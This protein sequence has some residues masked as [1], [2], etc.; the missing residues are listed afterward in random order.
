MNDIVSN[1]AART[2]TG[3]TI[4]QAWDLL[5][6]KYPILLVAVLMHGLRNVIATGVILFFTVSSPLSPMFVIFALIFLNVLSYLEIVAMSLKYV[7]GE[8]ARIRNVSGWVLT[9]SWLLSTVIF[10]I[11]VAFGLILLVIPGFVL[12][13]L[14]SVY[15]FAAVDGDGPIQSLRT[16]WQIVRRAFWPTLFVWLISLVAV[17]VCSNHLLIGME[18]AVDLELTLA[19]A[20]IYATGRAAMKG[21]NIE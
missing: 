3:R 13:V 5:L 12:G 15:G 19:L 20:F 16:S 17:F 2:T 9:S 21:G 8:S 1:S 14:L 10:V 11:A 7:R 18:F 4:S 6:D